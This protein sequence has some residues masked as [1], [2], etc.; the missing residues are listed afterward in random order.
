ML[1]GLWRIVP[2]LSMKGGSSA[3]HKL[4]YK[5][6][7][8]EETL[9]WLDCEHR[10]PF[11]FPPKH[12]GPDVIFRLKLTDGKVLTVALQIKLKPDYESFPKSKILEAIRTV[13]PQFFWTNEN[14]TVYS[15]ATHPLLH[16]NTW[17]LL[18][19]HPNRFDPYD[20]HDPQKD[21]FYG[22]LRRVSAYPATPNDETCKNI[23]SLA[24]TGPSVQDVHEMS[25]IPT[26][27]LFEGRSPSAVTLGNEEYRAEKRKSERTEIRQTRRSNLS[28]DNL[29]SGQRKPPSS[30]SSQQL[31]TVKLKMIPHMTEAEVLDG[32]ILD[33]KTLKAPGFRG[34]TATMNRQLL[35]H[36]RL[37]QI[38]NPLIGEG[39]YH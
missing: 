30:R 25:V 23:V 1:E 4:A 35:R 20:T 16:K 32:L 7:S 36:R 39:E 37:E 2:M 8:I 24:Q 33:M 26:A 15:H 11:L 3:A 5:T 27:K 21:H 6:D 10:E 9:R 12:F 13:T 29:K 18:K 19:N 31:D 38:R 22:L 34:L 14:G 17:N 28:T